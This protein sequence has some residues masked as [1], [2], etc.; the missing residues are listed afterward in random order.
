MIGVCAAL[1]ACR[2]H[3]VLVAACDLPD[4]EPAV[5]LALLALMP[6]SGGPE[7]VAL[8]GPKGPEPLLAIYRRD[9]LGAVQERIERGELSLQNLIHARRSVL[10]PTASLR[11]ID[12]ELRSLRNLNRPEDL[13]P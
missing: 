2:A 10:I 4:L 3:A 11:R 12:P 8:L 1:A 9:L 5:A 13:R 7:I 6:A